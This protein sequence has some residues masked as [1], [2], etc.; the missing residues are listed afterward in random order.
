MTI[1]GKILSAALLSLAV[2]AVAQPARAESPALG[3]VPPPVAGESPHVWYGTVRDV[4][5]ARFELTLRSGRVLV[6]E[7]STQLA[8]HH[9]L[10]LFAG[11]P[12]IVKGSVG[13]RGLIHADVVLR[14]HAMPAYWPPD[15]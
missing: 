1:N 15:R 3:A 13:A 14:S 2:L 8:L 5:G 4:R 10:L 9:G 6:V 11:R 12:V 7:Q